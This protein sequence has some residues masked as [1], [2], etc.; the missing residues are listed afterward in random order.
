MRVSASRHCDPNRS[1]GRLQ[2][3]GRSLARS[4]R[5]IGPVSTLSYAHHDYDGVY[6]IIMDR[7]CNIQPSRGC[8]TALVMNVAAVTHVLWAC[9]S[10]AGAGDWGSTVKRNTVARTGRGK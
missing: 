10:V 3:T 8:Y 1:I 9:S 2:V 4:P 6:S 7:L 5:Q